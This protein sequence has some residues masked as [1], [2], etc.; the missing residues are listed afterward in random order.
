MS[1]S[2]ARSRVGAFFR[3]LHRVAASGAHAPGAGVGS[4]VSRTAG[5]IIENG[6]DRKLKALTMAWQ[7]GRGMAAIVM[8]IRKQCLKSGSLAE[9]HALHQ[10]KYIE[11]YGGRAQL[12]APGASQLHSAKLERWAWWRRSLSIWRC[13]SHSAFQTDGSYRVCGMFCSLPPLLLLVC[14]VFALLASGLQLYRYFRAID[15]ASRAI[16]S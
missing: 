1:V 3:R 8:D 12:T 16:A 11:A 6:Y 4:G 10:Q 13:V 7:P 9:N 2:G 14:F 15:I 5:N